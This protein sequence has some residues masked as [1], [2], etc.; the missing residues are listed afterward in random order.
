[1][2][3]PGAA[4]AEL[5]GHRI[6]RTE[7]SASHSFLLEHHLE[8]VRNSAIPA[9]VS[10]ERGYRS[11]VG[12]AALGRLR[13][14]PSQ[15]QVPALLIQLWSVHGE[16]V[17][18]QARPDVPRVVNGKIVKY[19]TPAS[20][21]MVIDCPP[22][23]R[24]M[25]DDP[26]LP[27]FIT[28][29]VR[30]ADSAAAISLCCIDLL[31]VWN[32]RGSNEYGGKTALADW[33][34]VALNQRLVFLCFDSDV[35]TKRS[36]H[37]ALVRL[38]SFLES[39]GS[40]VK[41][42]YQPPGEHG[43]KVGLDDF[44]ASRIYDGLNA[45]QIRRALL[46]VATDQLRKPEQHEPAGDDPAGDRR[47]IIVAAPGA[48]PWIVD[49]TEDLIVQNYKQ[50]RLFQ[51]GGLLV[52][53][54]V[55]AAA[56]RENPTQILRPRGAVVLKPASV[57]MLQ[58]VF[59]RAIDW[60][61]SKDEDSLI[62]ELPQIDCPAKVANV[63]LSRSGSWRL[64]TLVGVIEAPMLRPV[65]SILAKPGY[66]SA[67]GLL[68]HSDEEWLDVSDRP[69]RGELESVVRTLIE[70]F[71]EFPFV[72]EADLAVV[73]SAILTALQRRLL[74]SAPL[75]A[76]D[77][78]AQGSGKSLLADCVAIIASGRNVACMPAS[79]GEEELRKKFTSVLLAGDLVIL[80]DNITKPLNSDALAS[81]L[82]APTFADRLLAKNER[83]ELPTNAL[84]LATGNN[85][86]FSGDLPTRVIVSRIDPRT[87]RPEER[88]FAVTELR[89]H[90]REHRPVLVHAALT[91]LRAYHADG[92]PAQ[93]LK[94]FGRFEQWSNDL[95]SA[96]VWAGLADPCQTRERIVVQDP[97]RDATAAVL[98]TWHAIF[99]DSAVPLQ[100]VVE[101]TADDKG[102]PLKTALLE[103]AADFDESGKINTKRLA[104]WCRGHLDRVVGRLSLQ[105]DLACAHGGAK[106]WQVVEVDSVSS[107]GS[108]RAVETLD[109]FQDAK[110]TG[111]GES[112]RSE[113]WEPDPPNPPNLR[114]GLRNPAE[115]EENFLSGEE[116]EPL[117]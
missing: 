100:K 51:R 83:P 105:K 22:R 99:G 16:A 56:R 47:P 111:S 26:R 54:S 116:E 17:G 31:G 75:H 70:P 69:S 3:H 102:K 13:F 88:E 53:V 73:I 23:C 74:F 5:G 10:R 71:R 86:V 41:V 50:W 57:P 68:L 113:R 115:T 7:W 42:I 64:P 72:T 35:V 62:E 15:R 97:E 84:F 66:D 91:L 98:S 4:G 77:A 32:W 6:T 27:L 38:K 81:I 44:I 108:Y 33:E 78:P 28:E 85:L 36:V 52:R 92:H 48:L 24:P 93:G 112:A 25:L 14:A 8:L 29:G 109:R 90:V 79:G 67:T 59:T 58:D 43:E 96:V 21:R 12:K 107:V 103:V 94:P 63:Y 106:L 95:R 82:T 55:N 19:E 87:E 61:R 114:C 45:E 76:F 20:M 80:L 2:N 37:A 34:H 40:S 18:Y 49:R 30:K 117:A 11:E 101:T 65:G 110:Q 60:R 104:A 9:D 46:T 39:R 1:V 89:A